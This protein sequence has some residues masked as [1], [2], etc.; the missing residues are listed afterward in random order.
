PS[1]SI[2]CSVTSYGP[3]TTPHAAL[4]I[5]L[6]VPPV[7]MMLVTEMP[8]GTV[9]VLTTSEPALSWPSLT[10][11][12]VADTAVAPAVT[13]TATPVITGTVFSVVPEK[14]IGAMTE[15]APRLSGMRQKL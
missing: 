9:T 4:T 3:V 1:L 12:I 8:V 15:D 13:G 10:F 7:F 11:A 6:T 5:A 2:T 14:Q